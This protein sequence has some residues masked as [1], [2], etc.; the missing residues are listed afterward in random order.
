MCQ[1]SPRLAHLGH[2]SI[3]CPPEVPSGLL[4]AERG[5]PGPVRMGGLKC[6]R[7]AMVTPVGP[8]VQPGELPSPR[9]PLLCL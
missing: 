6:Q 5:R 7:D 4:P 1:A 8:A 2:P 3:D 9:G